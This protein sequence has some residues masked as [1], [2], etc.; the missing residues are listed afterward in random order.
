MASRA[1]QLRHRLNLQAAT[2]T[3]DSFG[4][5]VLT[6]STIATVWGSIEPLSGRELFAAQQVNALISARIRI[7]YRDDV[8]ARMRVVHEAKSYDIQ[9]VI[10]P[11][12]RHVELELMCA[13]GVI[14]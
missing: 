12:T 1:G 8:N 13:E 14:R 2:E 9:S 7:R 6:W 3:R 5:V 10:D 11:E 4:G